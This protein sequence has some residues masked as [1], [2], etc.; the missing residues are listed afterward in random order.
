MLKKLHSI[1]LY[2]VILL[3][4]MGLKGK[5]TDY[6]NFLSNDKKELKNLSLL[7][8]KSSKYSFFENIKMFFDKN[9]SIYDK[10]IVKFDIDLSLN[11]E[12]KIGLRQDFLQTL[13][14][15]Y[16]M[17]MLG[18]KIPNENIYIELDLANQKVDSSNID[19]F[20]RYVLLAYASKK[21]DRLYFDTTCLDNKAL[22]AYEALKAYLNSSIID[23]YSNA[24][25]LYVLTCT[26]DKKKFDIV[27]SSGDDIELT[28]FNRVCNIYDEELKENIKISQSPIYAYH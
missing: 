28:D 27:W 9:S 8:V 4:A 16:S 13:N 24:K 14:I 25:N 23:N 2:P 1:S 21:V 18:S 7:E 12:K 5:K 17:S 10:T 20:L 11:P 3:F 26:K 15:Y 19:I 6:T 22:K